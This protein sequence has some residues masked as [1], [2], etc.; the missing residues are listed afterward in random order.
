MYEI[1]WISLFWC[2]NGN[3]LDIIGSFD[4]IRTKIISETQD[5]PLSPKHMKALCGQ[6]VSPFLFSLSNQAELIQT[7]MFLVYD[8][9]TCDGAKGYLMGISNFLQMLRLRRHMFLHFSHILEVLLGLRS[10]RS[11]LEE[12]DG[13]R[14]VRSCSYEL[15]RFS[16]KAEHNADHS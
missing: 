2:N 16:G 15:W 7:D 5:L 12:P 14:P 10:A 11:A 1:P 3:W 13:L 6:Q 8:S 4:C 9:A